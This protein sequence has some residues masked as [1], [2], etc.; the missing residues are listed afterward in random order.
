MIGGVGLDCLSF[1]HRSAPVELSTRY[2]TPDILVERGS[3]SVT[4]K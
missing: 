3:M 1:G 4:V 2:T